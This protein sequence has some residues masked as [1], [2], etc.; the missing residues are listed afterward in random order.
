MRL[1][2][3]RLTNSIVTWHPVAGLRSRSF[4]NGRP[5]GLLT[6]CT[7]TIRQ[8]GSRSTCGLAR[9]AGA[10]VAPLDGERHKY[11]KHNGE[12]AESW[13]DQAENIRVQH[14]ATVAVRASYAPVDRSRSR[15][16]P[17][18]RLRRSPC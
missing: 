10:G 7:W 12:H 14:A 1:T 5:S 17:D 18:R 13:A 15:T 8:W 6:T 3:L 2:P 16:Q 4:V 9:S 11:G